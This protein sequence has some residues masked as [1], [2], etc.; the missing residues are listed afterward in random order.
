MAYKG[1]INK[2]VQAMYGIP[3][4]QLTAE[5]KNILH[6]DSLRRAKLIKDIE[7]EARDNNLK[8]FDDEAKM[9]KVLASIYADCQKELLSRI[10][11]TM[12]EVKDKGGEWSYANMSELTR[13]R[14]LFT[15]ITA[16]LNKLGVKE[17][18]A[19]YKGLED[20]YTDQF[21]R[22][23]YTLG[24]FTGVKANFNR[25]NPMLIK[26]TLDYPWS[27]AMFSDRIWQAKD[28]LGKNLRIGLTQSM[29]LGE[30]IPEITKRILNN[31][32]TAKYNAERL[33]RSE[34][35]RVS[36]VAHDHVWEDTG[37]EEVKYYAA[38]VKSSSPVCNKCKVYDGKVYKRGT[39]PTLPIHPNCKCT[40]IP[41]VPQTFKPN[42]LN[43]LTGSVR[44]AESYKKW[45]EANK[46]KI[47]PDG[48]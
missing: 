35:K 17:Q 26:Q 18:Q 15:Q 41:V 5:Q 46:D 47:N 21:L 42:E 2:E 29:I 1:Y 45:I 48:S 10:A 28:I 33:A 27:G 13:N 32:D 38:G 44:G 6:A 8:A 31:I 7:L 34:V 19:M 12:T 9:E 4:S 22:E 23:V 14:G 30:G 24:Q 11:V 40:Y 43:E 37:V 20:I 3:Y 39:E 36:Y 25:L 16:E